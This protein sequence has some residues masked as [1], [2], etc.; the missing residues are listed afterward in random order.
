MYTVFSS[1]L[2]FQTV[3]EGDQI[4]CLCKTVSKIMLPLWYYFRKIDTCLE[5][6]TF[7]PQYVI[8]ATLGTHY[9]RAKELFS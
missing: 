3:S 5:E 8:L 7:N 9:E 2:L 4:S 6:L 1:A